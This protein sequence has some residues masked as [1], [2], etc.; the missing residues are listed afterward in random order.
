MLGEKKLLKFKQLTLLFLGYTNTKKSHN[1][2]YM[3]S[4]FI[5]KVREEAKVDPES[6]VLAHAP[7]YKDSSFIERVS[8][9]FL[10]EKITSEDLRLIKELPHSCLLSLA[11]KDEYTE[12]EQLTPDLENDAIDALKAAERLSTEDILKIAPECGERLEVLKSFG[13][14]PSLQVDKT[15]C[16]I[17]GLEHLS[18]RIQIVFQTSQLL[19]LITYEGE[20]TNSPEVEES[21][22]DLAYKE[23]FKLALKDV[24]ERRPSLDPILIIREAALVHGVAEWRLQHL[25]DE[26]Q[27]ELL[28][29]V[30]EVPATSMEEGDTRF[31]ALPEFETISASTSTDKFDFGKKAIEMIECASEEGCPSTVLEEIKKISNTKERFEIARY[32]WELSK[33]HKDWHVGLI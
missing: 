12:F 10:D 13:F 7:K 17:Q 19:K 14:E 21:E 1:K 5:Q 4:T 30:L 8:N 16:S 27:F 15:L 28:A 25:L 3:P 32:L 9:A 20:V 6:W 2:A 26:R 22:R 33:Y 18:P 31:L 24:I 23:R 11:A 29:A